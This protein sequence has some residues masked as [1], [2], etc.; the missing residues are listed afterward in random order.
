VPALVLVLHPI[1]SAGGALFAL[2]AV[3]RSG[4]THDSL[5]R[6]VQLDK[7]VLTVHLEQI[8]DFPAFTER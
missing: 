5:F 8:I 6:V 3:F 2:R 7:L 1:C 4:T